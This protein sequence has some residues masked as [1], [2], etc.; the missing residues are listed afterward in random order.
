MVVVMLIV[1]NKPLIHSAKTRQ[2]LNNHES[3]LGNQFATLGANV[4]SFK[5]LL[6]LPWILCLDS[7]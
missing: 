1:E 5:Y 2:K 7:L 4:S 6:A 3:T